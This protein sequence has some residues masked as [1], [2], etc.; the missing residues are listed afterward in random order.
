MSFDP[1]KLPP[2]IRHWLTVNSNIPQRYWTSDKQSATDYFGAWSSL[3]TEWMTQLMAGQV[4]KAVGGIGTTGVGLLFDGDPGMGK[5]SH[6]VTVLNEILLNLP[7]DQMAINKIFHFKSDAIKSRPVY[8]MT[9]TDFLDM[10]KSSFTESNEATSRFIEGL[11]GRSEDDSANVRVLV[12]DDVGKEYGS[13]YDGFSFDE[14]LR[15]R[16]D[17]ALPTIVTT[18]VDRGNWDKAYSE[19]MGSFVFEAFRR[20]KLKGPDRRYS[21]GK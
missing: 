20:V 11:Y 21:D 7:S 13:K 17:K 3:I 19:A 1:A 9:M 14:L 6:A 10:K 5:T 2:T 12:L 16:Y 15:S 4:I 18:N 8:Y